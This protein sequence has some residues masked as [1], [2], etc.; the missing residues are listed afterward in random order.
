MATLSISASGIATGTLT[1]LSGATPTTFSVSVSK[2]DAVEDATNVTLDIAPIPGLLF[3]GHDITDP[4]N[5]RNQKLFTVTVMLTDTA[6][7]P[8]GNAE[9][10][11][12]GLNNLPDGYTFDGMTRTV[13][14]N[15]IDGWDETRAIPL[16]KLNFAEFNPYANT[17][18][19]LMRH[20]ALTEDIELTG[21]NNWNAIG[22]GNDQ[23]SGSFNG[24]GHIITGLNINSPDTDMQ[25]M[26]GRVGYGSTV[27]NVGIMQAYVLGFR[28]VGGIAGYN[29]GTVKNC[30]VSGEVLGVSTVGGV[31][32]SNI[33]ATLE[34]CYS[35]CNVS[36]SSGAVG[37][38]A[39]QNY[40]GKIRRCYATANVKGRGIVGGIVGNT[41][42]QSA[43]TTNCIALN[44][45]ITTT[46]SYEYAGRVSGGNSGTLSSNYALVTTQVNYNKNIHKSVESSE[47]GIDGKDISPS[48]IKSQNEWENAGFTFDSEHWVWA[49]LDYLPHLF[50][51]DLSPWPKMSGS[52]TPD[53]PFWVY[54]VETL[55]KVMSLENGWYHDSHYIQLAHID[56]NGKSISRNMT[57]YYF[58]GSYDG[59]LYTISNLGMEISDDL[60]RAMFSGVNY[61]GTVKNLG[62]LNIKVFAKNE[63]GS[64]AGRNRGNIL[65][66]Y[67][68]GAITGTEQVGGIAGSNY[69]N[70]MNCYF[71][72]TV[73]GE[74]AVGGVE[75]AAFCRAATSNC[76]AS[77][78]VIASESLAGGVAGYVDDSKILKC[79][80]K[81][82]VTGRSHVGGIMGGHHGLVESCFS[83]GDIKADVMA[84][85]YH[86][87]AGGIVG[88]F[89]KG[90]VK[91]CYSMCN[92]N[93]KGY[94]AGG[95]IGCIFDNPVV[96]FCFATGTVATETFLGG[97]VGYTDHA[98]VIG[99]VALNK[100]ISR[101]LKGY[102]DAYRVLN[103][104]VTDNI[105]EMYARNDLPIYDNSRT[106]GDTKTIDSSK[107]TTF[108][109]DGKSVMQ[110]TNADQYNNIAFWKGIGFDFNE[111]WIWDSTYTL[112]N[113]A[114]GLPRLREAGVVYPFELQ[115]RA[116]VAPNNTKPTGLTDPDPTIM[117]VPAP[118]IGH[119]NG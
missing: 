32:G 112:H 44:N 59:N 61:S 60:M 21:E 15:I 77:G 105:R 110:G 35:L 33:Y 108:D 101:R 30:F 94:G 8:N 67:A 103:T 5:S 98:V 53:D 68:T 27:K 4:A 13:K 36:G 91:D 54:D 115:S 10:E 22:S 99:C 20:F 95:V 45:G 70:I 3:S 1:P 31:V 80:S 102:T 18:N 63:V 24:Q 51:S 81:S 88:M 58:D 74:M 50:A 86:S 73:K 40:C 25:G 107:A 46:G 55:Q 92:I 23:F 71:Q 38:V 93:A 7:F 41:V 14:V 111:L 34:D 78:E 84:E 12:I 2:F 42:G 69:G 106:S 85:Y 39:G 75:G 97:A 47:T 9:V 72:G 57:L 52:G 66:C 17:T 6:E 90:R 82:N 48:N 43:E 56:M 83:E 116:D 19:G 100:Y 26:F 76:S 62:L 64:I 119:I 96:E 117:Q 104:N 79:Y 11:I 87:Y 16:S 65:N 118:Q 109:Q 89:D 29:E 28:E 114:M 113:G 49:N 37:G